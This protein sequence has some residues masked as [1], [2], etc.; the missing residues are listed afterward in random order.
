MRPTNHTSGIQTS[1]H[2]TEEWYHL[3]YPLPRDAISPSGASGHLQI[4]TAPCRGQGLETGK[5]GLVITS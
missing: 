3:R 4:D 1:A 5:K 2:L